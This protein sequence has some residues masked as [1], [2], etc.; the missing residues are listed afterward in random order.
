MSIGIYDSGKGGEMLVREL[1]QSR[2]PRQVVFFEDKDALPLGNKSE[3]EILEY[4]TR[5]VENL[6]ASGVKKVF[7]ACNTASVVFL[8][9]QS[10]LKDYE[11]RVFGISSVLIDVLGS[12][13]SDLR[14]K[15]GLL[16]GT[17]A[18]VSSNVYQTHLAE[19]GFDNLEFYG[20]F[21]LA[22]NIQNENKDLVKKELL[23]IASKYQELDYVIIGCTHYSWISK[24]I[25]DVLGMHIEIVDPKDKLI[26]KIKEGK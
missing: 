20:S 6:F 1:I 4:V 12:Q 14:N 26:Q 24:D 5:G 2:F 16:L 18:T 7:L 19:Q 10:R 15:K 9:N 3:E 23:E 17:K 11:G 13:N 21:D 22:K 25:L 8:K